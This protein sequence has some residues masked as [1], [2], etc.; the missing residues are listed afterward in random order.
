M[1]RSLVLTALLALICSSIFVVGH[2][3]V[4]PLSKIHLQNIVKKFDGGNIKI[5][6]PIIRGMGEVVNISYSGLSSKYP[7]NKDWIGVWSPKPVN[8][9]Y[10]AMSATKYIYVTPDASGSGQIPL[11]LLNM[12]DSVMVAYFT[13]GLKTPVMLAESESVNFENTALPMHIHLALTG[14]PT[15]MRVDWTSAQ[16]SSKQMFLHYGERPNNLTHSVKHVSTTTYTAADMCGAPAT[17]IGYRSPGFLHSALI[18]NLR[19]NTE[20]FYQVGDSTPNSVSRV[21][22]FF[23][24]PRPEADNVEF[25]IFG[26][27]GQVETDG[28]NEASQMEGSILTTVALNKDIAKG[29]VNL[30]ASAAVFHIGDISYARGYATLW[31]QFF[32]QISGMTPHLPWMTVDGNHERDFPGSGSLFNG[33]DSGGECGVALE[34]RFKMPKAQ[35]PSTAATVSYNDTTWWSVN[36]GPVH[37]TVISTEHSFDPNSPQYSWIMQD[38]AQVDR[39]KTPFLVLAGHRPIYIDS[40]NDDPNGGDLSVGQALIDYIEPLMIKY[41]VDVTFFG[42]HHSYQRTC[43]LQNFTC[44]SDSSAPIHIV[45]GAAAAFDPITCPDSSPLF[46]AQS[47]RTP[48]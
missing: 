24:P 19:P 10:S 8:G 32:Y 25:V 37:F 30:A 4:H 7:G 26:D 47:P 35:M 5:D 16:D 15:E 18:E 33:T 40:T 3:D 29:R 2:F 13:G 46:H 11:W 31:E 9:N 34:N 6:A 28:S 22:N 48:L 1:I 14:N 20:Y 21:L 17:T 45:T 44:V 27:L 36:F 39:S 41:K 12:R 42:H 38:L 43:P 23:S